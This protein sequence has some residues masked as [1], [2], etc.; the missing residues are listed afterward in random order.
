MRVGFI[1]NKARHIGP[2]E[3]FFR[4]KQLF[5]AIR[6][7]KRY[8]DEPLI[9]NSRANQLCSFTPL[10]N[11]T[12][13]EYCFG[14]L[15]NLEFF[16]KHLSKEDGWP[17]LF[18]DSGEIATA[19]RLYF[20]SFS[21]DFNG[22]IKNFYELNKLYHLPRLALACAHTGNPIFANAVEKDLAHW[23]ELNP[24]MKG[25]NWKSGLELSIRLA[26]IVAALVI[27]SRC[28]QVNLTD[29][30]RLVKLTMGQ[31]QNT[32]SKFSSRGNH[33]IVELVGY[34]FGQ[35]FLYQVSSDCEID[36]TFLDQALAEELAI[37][38]T[39]DGRGI[40]NSYTYNLLNLESALWAVLLFR[41]LEHEPS[42]IILKRICSALRFTLA[43]AD[44]N[45]NA[46][47]YG[48][49]DSAT[50]FKVVSDTDLETAARISNIRS[51]A[52]H[53]GFDL[54]GIKNSSNFDALLDMFSPPLQSNVP[55][56]TKQPKVKIFGDKIVVATQGNSKSKM[57]NIT[58]TYSHP[59][60]FGHAHSDCN[61][62]WWS[63]EGSP[64]LIDP[65]SYSYTRKPQER[66][67]FRSVQ[68]HNTFWVQAVPNSHF[69]APF[70]QKPNSDSRLVNVFEDEDAVHIESERSYEDPSSMFVRRRVKF[71]ERV[72]ELTDEVLKGSEPVALHQAFVFAPS[73]KLLNVMDTHTAELEFGSYKLFVETTGRFSSQYSTDMRGDYSS[74]F[75]SLEQIVRM[76]I[77]TTGEPLTTK[78]ELII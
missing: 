44:I 6:Q 40:E 60:F 77:T 73:I 38:I 10:V 75:N 64:V 5:R 78:L 33:S 54:L 76:E 39:E 43:L 36:L 1:L 50:F 46:P 41:T 29:Y 69:I 37:Q 70:I 53:L 12:D 56:E 74:R 32:H 58:K 19:N 23:V 28:G 55:F 47:R 3:V 26:N 48:D 61:S 8:R 2:R 4:C 31:I 7:F 21:A 67:A 18:P 34:L 62:L 59:P 49:D 16:G 27:L 68:N 51:L 24:F 9:S 45:D 17:N 71:S 52:H 35:Y 13:P 63:Y 57:V 42:P 14:S 65:G 11:L 25:L 72:L 66:N 20:Q 15:Q 30:E 22:A